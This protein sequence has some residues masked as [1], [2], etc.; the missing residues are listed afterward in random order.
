MAIKEIKREWSPCQLDYVK[1]YLL[2]SEKDVAD[3]PKCCVGSKATVSETDNEYFCTADGWKL[4]TEIEPGMGGGGG[5]AGGGSSPV[6]ILPE[7]TMDVDPD[8]GIAFIMTPMSATPTDGGTAKI[9]YNGAEYTSPILYISDNG[10]DGYAMGNTGAIG[11]PGGNSD[12]PF[13][14]ALYI[15]ETDGGYGMF[16]PMD[17]ATS[18]TLSIT[19]T[20]SSGAADSPVVVIPF[21]VAD[22]TTIS[23]AR[24]FDDILALANSGKVVILTGIIDNATWFLPLMMAKGGDEGAEIIF[25][26]GDGGDNTRAI[27]YT[28]SGTLLIT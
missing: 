12:A 24:S 11:I 8:A 4:S 20:A 7:T 6:V 25:A 2:H 26:C 9:V 21:T 15:A 22:G 17:G 10:L 28:R 3:L 23:I 1:T 5:S 14:V 18:V 16:M 13:L 19:E 27:M